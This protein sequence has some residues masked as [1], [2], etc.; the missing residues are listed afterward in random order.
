MSAELERALT[1]AVAETLELM[2]FA[3]VYGPCAD[4]PA[5]DSF[6]TAVRFHG[7]AEGMVRLRLDTPAAAEL[8]AAFLGTDPAEISPDNI[9]AVAVELTNMVCGAMLSQ[10][11]ESGNF[12][13]DQPVVDNRCTTCGQGAVSRGYDIGTGRVWL[14]VWYSPVEEAVCR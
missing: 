14:D 8:A 12:H 7:D 5:D 10:V 13:L 2:C 11:R 1:E 3:G 6:C 4:E 9:G